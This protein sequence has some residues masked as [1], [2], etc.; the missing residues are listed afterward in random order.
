MK[1]LIGMLAS[2]A[3]VIGLLVG[4]ATVQKPADTPPTMAGLI[5]TIEE[6]AYFQ[7][8]NGILSKGYYNL[9]QKTVTSI[10]FPGPGMDLP[11]EFQVI[12]IDAEEGVFLWII[13]FK[14]GEL[15]Y[16]G[17]LFDNLRFEDGLLKYDY[18]MTEQGYMEGLDAYR[19]V[20]EALAASKQSAIEAS[21]EFGE[22]IGLGGLS[23]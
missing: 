13:L 18:A 8:H 5:K 15:V 16:Q 12:M 14:T 7:P 20:F 6:T 10:L 19:P 22:R 17:G 11:V 21:R 9:P 2:L 4:C 23:I 1:R 3:L